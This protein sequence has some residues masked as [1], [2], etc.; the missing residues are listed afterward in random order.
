MTKPTVLFAGDSITDCERRD[1]PAGLGDGYVLRITRALAGQARWVNRGISGNSTR[2]LRD[3]W[4]ADVLAER[5]SLV[6][7]LV[8]INDTW[9]R[10]DSGTVTTPADFEA[11]Y[12]ALLDPLAAGGVA[13]VLVEPFLLPV[14]AE[15]VEWR[16]DL[17]PK[18]DIV[19]ELAREYAAVLVPADT[20]LNAAGD[21]E[22]LA[23]DGIHPSPH[24]T[25]LLAKL[26]L[27]H[28]APLLTALPPR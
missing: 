22:G 7:V 6:S 5:P 10:Y 4:T 27:D 18:I 15:Q 21:A 25:D 20:A 13:L 8:G 23:P 24:G 11:N 3:R 12:R 17:D 16:E 9:R 19:R 28:A 26:W 2:D 1:D 14:R